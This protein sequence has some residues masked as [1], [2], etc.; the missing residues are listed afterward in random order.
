MRDQDECSIDGQ[1]GRKHWAYEII[2]Q[3][4]GPEPRDDRCIWF[5]PGISKWRTKNYCCF[6]VFVS[7][8]ITHNYY[9]G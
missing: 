2:N 7:A 9:Y 5:E 1:Y 8:C 4:D 3:T 6:K